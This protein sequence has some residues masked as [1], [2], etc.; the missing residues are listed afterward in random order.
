MV[1]NFPP[2]KKGPLKALFL[3]KTRLLFPFTSKDAQQGQQVL[4]HID[5][6]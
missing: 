6:V 2:K 1:R 3:D 5:D 4:E